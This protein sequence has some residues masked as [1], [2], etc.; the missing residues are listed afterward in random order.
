MRFL[1]IDEKTKAQRGQVACLSSHSLEVAE[2]GLKPGFSV[3]EDGRS[4]WLMANA[5]SDALGACLADGGLDTSSLS[6]LTASSPPPLADQ[7]SCCQSWSWQAI[8]HT[9]LK[10]VG[11]V[12]RQVTL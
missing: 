1:P 3:L 12:Q 7:G 11:S 9:V 10:S 2:A 8:T 5:K 6:H 4:Q